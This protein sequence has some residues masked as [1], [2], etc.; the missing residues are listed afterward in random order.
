MLGAC[1]GRVVSTFRYLFA[2]DPSLTCSG[3]ALFSVGD[4]SV[5]AVGK[6]RGEPASIPLSTRLKTLQE[7]IVSLL[8]KLELSSLDIM[9]CESPTT[10]RDPHAAIKVEQVRSIF[11]ASARA[12][13]ISVPGR[14][15]PRSVHFEVMGLK[16]PQLGR[17]YI[18]S[19]AQQVAKHLFSSDLLKLGF[20][21][22]ERE[23]K[24]HQDIIDALLVGQAALSRVRA[25]E[26]S[27]ASLECVFDTTDRRRSKLSA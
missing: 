26:F 10:M 6:I 16:G 3:W 25:A 13:G 21:V 7:R 12:L 15:N 24:R 8:N 2:V 22:E 11:E 23:M 5:R 18:K 27:G 17:A 4:G 1:Y 14:I 20:S 19:A 9:A